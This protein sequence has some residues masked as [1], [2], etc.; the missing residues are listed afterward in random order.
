MKIGIIRETRVPA[1]ARA[2]FSP[3]DV[4]RLHDVLGIDF[5]VQPSNDRV[6]IDEQYRSAGAVISE[7]L[8]QCDY[9]FGIKEVKPEAFIPNKHYFFF[10]HIREDR[11]YEKPMLRA[12]LEKGITFTDYEEMLDA[13]GSKSGIFGFYAGVVGTYNT[14][15]LYGLKYGLYDIPQSQTHHFK[16][17]LI[18]EL[19]QVSDILKERHVK[20][21]VTGSGKVS[22]GICHVLDSI[23]FVRVNKGDFFKSCIASYTVARSK[24]MYYK[25]Y[26]TFDREEFHHIPENYLAYFKDYSMFSDILISGHHWDGKAPAIFTKEIASSD[27][28][29]IRVIGDITADIRG[30]IETTTKHCSHDDPFFDISRKTLEEIPLFSE[31]DS[32]SVTAVDTLPGVLAT[33]ASNDFSSML[34]SRIVKGELL[35]DERPVVNKATMIV[36]GSLSEGYEHL[37]KWVSRD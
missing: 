23:G 12:M 37:R 7:D 5:I 17:T 25:E 4:K 24:D 34:C 11:P 8:S 14:L 21:V 32:I 18:N 9:L 20:I 31:K 13:L 30:S 29:R 35:K 10:G 19:I 16:K 2:A 33:E 15:R 3:A 36:N 22:E 26:G 1:D 6:F 27:Y 28:N